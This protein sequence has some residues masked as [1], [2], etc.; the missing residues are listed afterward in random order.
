MT[1]KLVSD[2]GTGSGSRLL[3]IGAPAVSS[4]WSHQAHLFS[5]F[6]APPFT[7][8]QF[9]VASFSERLA[10]AVAA[11]TENASCVVFCH[12]QLFARTEE[13]EL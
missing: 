11:L 1:Q 13:D 4:D 7:G 9:N 8:V 5:L 2:T 12:F 6:R 10:F 3:L